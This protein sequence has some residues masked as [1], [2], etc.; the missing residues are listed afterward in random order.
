[1]SDKKLIALCPNFG[2]DTGLVHTYEAKALLENAG[3][4]VAICPVYR[5]KETEKVCRDGSCVPIEQLVDRASLIVVFGGDGTIL[6]VARAA[7]AHEVPIIGVNLGHKGF[8]AELDPGEGQ[9]LLR[10]A[11]GDYTPIRRMMLDV[12][13]LR[14]GEVI[15]SNTALN[16]AVVGS[17]ATTISVTAYGD[18]SKIL[19]FRGDGVVIATPTGSTAY[20]LSAGGPLVE[21]NAENIIITP[22]CAH[23]ITAKPFVLAPQRKVS[24]IASH[25]SGNKFWLSVDGGD[26]ITMQ[27]NDIVR[28]KKSEH[29]TLMAHVSM[30]SL[31]D[32]V[33]EK[34]GGK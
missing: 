23:L 8:M 20:S 6:K 32:I 12:E 31:Y 30:K 2:R 11:A 18:D 1:M 14:D 34:L 16:D 33:F 27:D 26:P 5:G 4:E 7:M 15:Y 24:V 13:L 3:Y 22:I 17:F 29:S 28:V 21:P 25:N 19:E 10:A 9:L